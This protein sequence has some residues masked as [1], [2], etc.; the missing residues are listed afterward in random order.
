MKLKLINKKRIKGEYFIRE[1]DEVNSSKF[2]Y[3]L[4]DWISYS[5]YINRVGYLLD[6]QI[7][8]SQE[9]EDAGFQIFCEKADLDISQA[10]KVLEV[11]NLFSPYKGIRG[12]IYHKL[13]S[14]KKKEK[15]AEF[16]K[17]GKIKDYQHLYDFRHIFFVDLSE[18]HQSRIISK[19]R[20]WT[21]AY[22]SPKISDYDYEPGGLE[23][24]YNQNL[25]EVYNQDLSQFILVH[26]DDVIET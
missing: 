20:R 7:F 18:I 4:E 22:N 1:R 16:Q 14:L 11:L 6:T 17:N 24:K 12:K 13:V 21:G 10:S 19:V 23:P 15:L 5:R 3:N 26:P 9:W 8:T 2:E 25:Y